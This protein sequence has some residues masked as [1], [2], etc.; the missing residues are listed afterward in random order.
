MSK[1]LVQYRLSNVALCRHIAGFGEKMAKKLV[2]YRL[3]NGPFVCRSQLRSVAGLGPKTFEQ[4]A[5]FLRV[6]PQGS[7]A[8]ADGFVS[9]CL[10]LS[11]FVC[12]T[13]WAQMVI[14]SNNKLIYRL[15]PYNHISD[16]LV[17]LHWLCVPECVH[18]KVALLTFKVLHDSATQY[19]G[20]LVTVADLPG[21]RALRSASTSRLVAPPHQTVYCWQPQL[22][23]GTVC[24]RPSSHRHHCRLSAVNQKLTFFP[25]VPSP[26]VVTV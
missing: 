11:L 18:Y 8:V 15:R 14:I 24:Q 26:D 2:Q 23:S 17:T 6:M 10:S 25:F 12:L 20:P 21:L 7:S 13:I 4:C 22:K 5:G 16:A 1:K 19:L 3:S 9:L